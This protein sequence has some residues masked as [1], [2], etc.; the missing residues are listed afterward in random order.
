MSLTASLAKSIIGE[1][2]VVEDDRVTQPL[3]EDG[4][5]VEQQPAWLALKEAATALQQLQAQ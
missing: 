1:P 2:E 4:R 5:P 3:V